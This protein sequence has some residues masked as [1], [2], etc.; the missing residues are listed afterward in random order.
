MT[1]PAL[2][3]SFLESYTAHSASPH[4]P[5]L[6]IAPRK[7]RTHQAAIA[8]FTRDRLTHSAPKAPLAPDRTEGMGC[9]YPWLSGVLDLLPQGVLVMSADLTVLYRNAQAQPI[10]Q[11]LAPDDRTG[12]SLP[13]P[14][15]TLCKK[16]VRDAAIANLV[17]ESETSTGQIIRMQVQRLSASGGNLLHPDQAWHTDGDAAL[18][19]LPCLV[20]FL[21]NCHDLIQQEARV[22]QQKYDLTERETEVWILL[23]QELSYQ[24]IAQRLQISLNTV[25]THV[26]NVYA[27]RRSSS[28][29]TFAIRTPMPPKTR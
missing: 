20:V 4:R 14:V 7:N 10:C 21:E 27:K 12:L 13:A 3:S 17:M 1:A 26:K 19:T 9:H 24:E 23:R 25:K 28:R 15:A 18:A 2:I 29:E 16:M 5:R 8:P 22:Q 11:L 6:P